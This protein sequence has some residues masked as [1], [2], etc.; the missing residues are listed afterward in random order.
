MKV[1]IEGMNGKISY[2][3]AVKVGI[4]EKAIT[5]YATGD[6]PNLF[7]PV[8]MFGKSKETNGMYDM[9]F[10]TLKTLWIDEEMVYKNE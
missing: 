7:L 4:E 8:Y 10:G 5:I 6:M 2:V 3:E 1:K 9:P